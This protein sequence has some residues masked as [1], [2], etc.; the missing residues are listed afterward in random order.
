MS[1]ILGPGERKTVQAVTLGEATPEEMKSILAGFAAYYGTFDVDAGKGT[2]IHHVTQSL[3]PNW[4]GTDLERRYAFSGNEMA[5]TA[6][7]GGN[8]LTLVWRKR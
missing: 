8:V 5:L 1:A 2:V 7:I 3:H 6:E 4:V